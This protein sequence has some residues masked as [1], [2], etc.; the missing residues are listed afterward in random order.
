MQIFLAQGV[1]FGL[2]ASGLFSCGIVSVGQWFHK[3]KA[4]ALG[5]VLMGSSTGISYHSSNF[6]DSEY[7]FMVYRRCSAPIISP[8]SHQRNWV[9]CSCSVLRSDHSSSKYTGMSAHERSSTEEE[10]GSESSLL[11]LRIIQ[12]TRLQRLFS[13]DLFR[14]VSHIHHSI[15]CHN[16]LEQS[17]TEMYL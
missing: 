14:S 4:L 12:N 8:D 10:M 11:R 3:R 13:R 9:A 2:A 15:S 16:D 7:L 1:G 17:L 5:L 6:V